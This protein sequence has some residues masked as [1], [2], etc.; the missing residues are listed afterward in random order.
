MTH[1][2]FHVVEN[3]ISPLQCEQIVQQLGLSRP[4]YAEDGQP[5]KHERLL[6]SDVSGLIL[7][8]LDAIAPLIEKR[9]GGTLQGDPSLLFQQY[10]ENPKAPAEARWAEG[11]KYL[12]KKWTK[13][14]DIDLVGFIWLKDFHNSV[15]LDPR[16]EVYGG[17]LEFWTHN[18]SLTPVRGTLA[19]FPATPHF[20]T[21]MSHVMLGQLEQIRVTMKLT[22]HGGPWTYA[23]T[24][25]PGSYKD[26]FIPEE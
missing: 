9:Y 18:F 17:K 25:F 16:F 7:S 15:P 19:L 22:K 4:D 6:P 24:N 12:R 23:P 11:W 5:I 3:L 13:V 8:E 21:A 2:P 1:S 20:E 26:W 10:F 14:K